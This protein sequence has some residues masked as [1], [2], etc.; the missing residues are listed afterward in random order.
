MILPWKSF[1][2]AEPEGEYLALLTVLPLKKYSK[3]PGFLRATLAIQRQLAR[4]KGLVGYSLD[5]HPLRREFWT[6]SVWEDEDAL[7]DFVRA[8]PHGKTTS[9]LIPHMGATR[10]IRWKIRGSELPPQWSDAKRRASSR[11]VAA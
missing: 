3:I 7:A 2:K 10:F 1:L 11:E 6:L 8:N 4:S 9:D 5:A